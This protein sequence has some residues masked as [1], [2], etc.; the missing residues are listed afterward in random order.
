MSELRREFESVF[1]NVGAELIAVWPALEL[2]VRVSMLLAAMDGL[3]LDEDCR[4]SLV[5]AAPE[6][7]MTSL[8]EEEDATDD[9]STP[10]LAQVNGD[11]AAGSS[12]LAV[13]LNALRNGTEHS[14]AIW[15]PAV[16]FQGVIA[17][18]IG[19]RGAAVAFDNLKKARS[20]VLLQVATNLL[21]IQIQEQD[22]DVEGDDGAR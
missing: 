5:V 18:E 4:N 15:P 2:N 1:D 20:N 7:M 16:D 11:D 8:T 6:L 22:Q 21:L 3:E 13:V 19:E 10:P 12:V 9:V 14:E 17:A